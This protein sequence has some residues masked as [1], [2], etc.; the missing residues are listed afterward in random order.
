MNSQAPIRAH[1]K[2]TVLELMQ[3]DI[4]QEDTDALVNAANSSLVVGGGVDRAINKAAGPQLAEET[5]KLGG[6]EVGNAK[7]TKGYNLKAR[8]V[9]HAVGPVY[10]IDPISAPD[11]L[12]SAYRRSLEVLTEN[13]LKSVAFPAISTGIYGYPL[14][15]AAPIALKAVYDFVTTAKHDVELIR[16]VLFTGDALE[17]FVKALNELAA[18]HEDIRLES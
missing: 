1:I 7:I 10:I 15:E 12:A 17:A 9:I 3:G 14:N 18:K 11:W 8:H 6:C 2:N 4:T 16:F 5:S 13:G